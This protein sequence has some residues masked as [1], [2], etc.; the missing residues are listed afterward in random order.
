M[1]NQREVQ[2]LKTIV[3]LIDKKGYSPTIREIY[4]AVQLSSSSTVHSYLEKLENKGCIDRAI[5]NP[6]A[7]TVTERGLKLVKLL[8]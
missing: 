1:F 3:E 4:K 7:L 2:I 6:R 5:A 8:E